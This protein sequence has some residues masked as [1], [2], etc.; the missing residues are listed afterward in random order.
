VDGEDRG[1]GD[2]ERERP[3]KFPKFYKENAV[4]S[5]KL[6]T[7]VRAVQIGVRKP[8]E[9][10]GGNQTSTLT[11]HREV[12]LW[13]GLSDKSLSKKK[14]GGMGGKWLTRIGGQTREHSI[15]TKDVGENSEREEEAGDAGSVR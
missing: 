11:K 7:N 13:G 2:A 6:S 9:S 12:A 1:V 8:N 14:R 5:H 10:N 15:T 3:T 4:Y